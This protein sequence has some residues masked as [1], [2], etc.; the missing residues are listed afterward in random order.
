[1]DHHC[2]FLYRCIAKN[3]HRLFVQ[4]IMVVMLAMV[5]FLYLSMC[6]IWKI[7]PVIY[8]DFPLLTTHIFGQDPFLWSAMLANTLSLVWGYWLLY[9]QLRIISKGHTTY[10]QPFMGKTNLNTRQ[11]IHNVVLF[12]TASK[13]YV[14][15]PALLTV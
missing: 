14:K 12:M 11:R 15:D 3:N 1:M 2:L 8:N 4:L 7:Y 10:F 6:Y 9:Y 5:T 13:R